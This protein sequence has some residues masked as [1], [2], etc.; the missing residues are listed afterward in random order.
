[1]KAADEPAYLTVGTDVSAKYRGAFCEAKIKNVKRMVKV[2]VVLKGDSTS[3]IVQDDQVKGPL[4]VGSTV[5]VKNPEGG[6]SEGVISKLTDASWYTV[7]FDDGDEKTLRRTS[8]CL[9]GERHFAESETLDQLPLTNPEHFGTP[10]IGKKTNRG[11]RS[12]LP[13]AE[14]ERESSSS[15]EEDEDRRR[16]NDDL[17]GKVACVQAGAERTAWYLGLVI[18]PS[19]N[20]DLTVRKDQCLVRSFAD[21]K[22]YTVARKE[23]RV[24]TTD[25]ISKLEFSSK[26]GFDEAVLFLKTKTIPASWKMDMSE[27]L[28]SSSSDDEDGEEK[29]SEEDEKVE[30][31]EPEEEPDPEERDHFLQQLYKFMEDRGTPINKPPVLGYKDLNLFKLFRLVYHQGGCDS[32]ESGAVW[33]Q[34]YMDLGIPVL[35]SAASYN[36]KT[37]YRKYLY[38]FEEYCRSACIQFRT[39]HHNDPRPA[40]PVEAKV[41]LGDGEGE[42][43]AGI[44]PERDPEPEPR[45]EKPLLVESSSGSES[46]KEEAKE[47]RRRTASVTPVKLEDKEPVNEEKVEEDEE[48]PEELGD[49]GEPTDRAADDT[50]SRRMKPERRSRRLEESDKESDEEEQEDEDDDADRPR[51]RERDEREADE[52]CEEDPEHSLTGT[53]VRVKYGRGKTQKIYEANIKNTEMDDGEVLYLVHYY[54]WNVRY[55]EWVKADRIIWPVD[56]AGNKRRQKR[57]VKSKEEAEKGEKE[58]EKLPKPGAKRGRPPLRSTPPSVPRSAGSGITKAP[59][60]DGRS[61]G[62][63][64]RQD[65]IPNGEGTPR[66]RTRRT[67]GMYD[68]DRGSIEESGN[69]SDDTDSESSPEKK[70][71]RQGSSDPP[72]TPQDDQDEDPK[73]PPCLTVD[74]LPEPELSDSPQGPQI[75]RPC[76]Q[77]VAPVIK[78]PEEQEEETSLLPDLEKALEPQEEERSPHI[79]ARRG[80]CKEQETEASPVKQAICTSHTEGEAVALL[81]LRQSEVVLDGPQCPR[82]LPLPPLGPTDSDTD[83]A[84]EEI[85]TEDRRPIKRKSPEQRTPEKKVRM[86]RRE[87][88]KAESDRRLETPPRA[89]ERLA[90][91]GDGEPELRPGMPTL[92][93]E[94]GREEL[95]RPCPLAEAVLGVQSEL[96]SQIGPES[97][98]CHEVDL[99]DP[100]EREKP[101]GE[102]LLLAVRVEEKPRTPAAA[103]LHAL[104][105]TSAAPPLAPS[106]STTPSPSESHSTKSESDITIE[107]ESVAGES[108]EGLCESEAA[109][110]FEGSGSSSTSLQ[111][112]GQKR[113][114]DGSGSSSSKKQKR[115]QKRSSGSGTAGKGEKN[116][117]GH[118]SDSEDLPVTD[119]SSKL[120]PIKAPG[121][122]RAPKLPRSPG[123]VTPGTHNGKEGEKD[124]Q[125][126]KP[127]FSA[128]TYKWTFQLAELDNMTS[129]ERITFLQDK[130]QEIRKYY[131]SL[132][133][134]V[135]SID[136]RRKRLKKKERE[137]SHTTASTSSGSSDTGMSPSST[138]PSQTTVAVECR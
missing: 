111:D 79:K 89:E 38:G 115:G 108:Q 6:L 1:M 29:D 21:S 40:A 123:T 68:S 15:E 65:S 63:A 18:S 100:D 73:A 78:E 80:R 105:G 16:L 129:T 121:V 124:K 8:L 130:L 51:P 83:S 44:V 133:S 59:G 87:E 67:S 103:M 41:E 3:H 116:G 93:M 50:P 77:E 76:L 134:E 37:A 85:C 10:V 58:E 5:E 128:R 82:P 7:V 32:I 52:D 30:E 70:L 9:K 88:P 119:T 49:C 104:P 72:L 102:E 125:R 90:A 46:D 118:S 122:H 97:L 136:R 66:R 114:M 45:E 14:D 33:K 94:A 36:V 48:Q 69:S 54:G 96:I 26:K 27:I 23:I 53:K 55:D 138:S 127:A 24:L 34:I 62:K 92:S 120:T 137:V 17:L 4:R 11:R 84:T 126:D 112:R 107:V 42:P 39:I 12:S 135:A 43:E 25:N 81:S 60:S 113:S 2:K 101:T 98:V 31:V 35:N 131:M 47:G 64:P 95:L 56:K 109:N 91:A 61:S 75:E 71:T 86:E 28:E 22:F 20:D 13:I 132:K 19:C 99:D 57:K 117:A 106:P 110:G 74:F